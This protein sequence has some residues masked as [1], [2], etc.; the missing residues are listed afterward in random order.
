[1]SQPVSGLAA[2][3]TYYV[4]ALASNSLGTSVGTVVSFTTFDKPGVI[5]SP[6]TSV[7]STSAVLNGSADPNGASAVAWFRISP[8]DPG[9]CN[10]TF[11]TRTPATA[12]TGTSVGAGTVAVPYALG[13]GTLSPG[14]TYFYCAIAQNAYGTSFGAEQTFTTPAILPSVATGSATAL[15]STTA[16]LNGSANPGGADTTG[17]FRYSSSNPGAC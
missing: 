2:N 12:G 9:S 15:T 16:T 6:A 11:G 17:W 1:F 10:D 8:T 14:T 13:S 7:V 3:T 4:C 5:T